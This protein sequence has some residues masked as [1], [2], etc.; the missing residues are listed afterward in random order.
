MTTLTPR[1]AAWLILRRPDRRDTN[2]KIHWAQLQTAHP[3]ITEAIALSEDFVRLLRHRK[4]D[5]FEAWLQQA[6]AST[7][8]AL[9]RFAKGLRQD[10]AAV[11][12]ALSLPWSNGP[13]E[14]QI[15]RL[16]MIKRQMFGRANL[17]LLEKRFILDA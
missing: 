7:V 15:N 2:D 5:R 4:G 9:R 6:E 8:T 12:A 1:Q 14:G 16:K 17:D 13:V 10:Y 3:Q 11:Q